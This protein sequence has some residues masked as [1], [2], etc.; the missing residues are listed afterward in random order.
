MITEMDSAK[1]IIRKLVP[2]KLLRGVEQGFRLLRGLFWQARYGFP[3]RGMHVVAVTGTNGKTTTANYINEVLK[4]GGHKTALFT[5]A[6]IE[7][8]GKS[9]PNKTHFTLVKQSLVQQFFARSKKA[10][11]DWVVLEVTSH[12]I[13]QHRIMGVPVE[14][15][16]MTNLTQDHLDYHGTMEE[17]ARVKSLLF[18]AFKPRFCIL[19]TDDDWYQFFSDRSVGRSVTYGK[20]EDATF[21]LQSQQSG[22]KGSTAKFVYSGQQYLLKTSLQGSFNTYNAL[23]GIA[24]GHSLGIDVKT[25]ING[26][27]NLQA[28]PGRMESIQ[29]GQSFN[30]VVDFAYTPDALQKALVAL[31]E[32][33]KGSVRIVFG[34]TGDRD[35]TKRPLMGK[36]VA[37]CADA[38]YLTDDET[39]TEDPDRIRQA[40]YEGIEQAKGANKTKVIADR[41]E[42]IQQAFT[43][44]KAGDSI[45]LAG[46]GHET[47]R[48]MGGKQV[49]WDDRVI[50][51][52]LLTKTK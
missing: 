22:T 43:D 32:T 1:K 5:T 50:A 25:A 3:A 21:C 37:E 26:I 28:V 2:R 12:A 49:A 15:A 17:Y 8:A 39:Y 4:A 24:V 47:E 20:S 41:E 30:V 45:L 33:T 46:I 16:V 42:A 11:V 38:I 51:R 44:A 7:V 48:N 10:N 31:R 34:A 40:V 27:G 29:E 9:E 36:V 23:A 6:L 19:N 35:K 13:D 18:S 14:V 52:K